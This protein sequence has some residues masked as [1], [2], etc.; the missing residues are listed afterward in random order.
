MLHIFR[1]PLVLTLARPARVAPSARVFPI[2][3]T[4]VTPDVGATGPRRRGWRD[5]GHGNGWQ[6]FDPAD[7]DLAPELKNLFMSTPQPIPLGEVHVF[8]HELAKGRSEVRFGGAGA[9]EVELIDAAIV[10]LQEVRRVLG[11]G[12]TDDASPSD[13][14]AQ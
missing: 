3:T 1:A 8:A 10:E 6:A 2:I 4:G 13:H 14:P 12:P 5:D 7:P 9:S 11:G